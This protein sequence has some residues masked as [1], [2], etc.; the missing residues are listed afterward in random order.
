MIWIGIVNGYL[1]GLNFFD[2]NV[3]GPSFRQILQYHLPE[4]LENVDLE[5]MTSSISGFNF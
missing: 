5:T 2:V 4:I 1:V 3:S